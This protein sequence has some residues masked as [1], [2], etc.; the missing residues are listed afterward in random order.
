MSTDLVL[1]RG[2]RPVTRDE[3]AV[4]EV[5]PPTATWFPLSHA[6]VLDRVEHTLLDSGFHPSKVSLAL[7]ADNARCFGI[8]DLATPIR[9]GVSLTVGFR[10]SIDRSLP[11]AMCAGN[12]VFVCDNLAFR[13]EIVVARKHTKFGEVRFGEAIA[14]AVG[15]LNQF[16]E[17]EAQRI[18]FFQQNEIRDD[19]ADALILRAY[20]T[21]LVSHYYL[22]RV[23]EE[24]RKPTFADFEARTF[25]SLENA[26][27]TALADIGK[28]NP[29][30]YCGLTI[31]LQGLLTKASGFSTDVSFGPSI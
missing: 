14:R 3:L 1:H 18:Q 23:I 17:A 6:S 4:V 26:F 5:P 28:R 25:W 12:R 15:S 7:S 8:I 11:I 10:N 2:A 9:Q 19:K 29:Q 16:K 13:S 21:D 27:T 31:A 20:E 24:W 30:R 22:P